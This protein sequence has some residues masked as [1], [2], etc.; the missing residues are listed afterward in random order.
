MRKGS[1]LSG[2]FSFKASGEEYMQMRKIKVVGGEGDSRLNNN[3]NNNN[4]CKTLE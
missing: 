3:S 1:A 2:K 4:S